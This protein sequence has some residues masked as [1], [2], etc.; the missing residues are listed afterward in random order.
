MVVQQEFSNL[1]VAISSCY[2][3]LEKKASKHELLMLSMYV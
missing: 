3:E 2:M 1:N